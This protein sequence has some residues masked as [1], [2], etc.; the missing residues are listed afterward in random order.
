MLKLR[1]LPLLP[2][3]ILGAITFF[4]IIT[5]YSVCAGNFSP[6]CVKQLWRVLLGIIVLVVMANIKF[7]VWK[8]YAFSLYL[9]CLVAL[10]AVAVIGKISMGAQRWLRLGTLT[11]QPSEFMRI[12]L[13]MVLAKYFSTHTIDDNRRTE[14]LLIPTLLTIIPVGFVLLQP[15]LGT[16]MLLI[17]V[18]L[19]IL[20]ACGVQVWKF[21]MMFIGT[22]ICTPILWNCLYDYQKKRI[23]MFLNPEMDPCGSGYHII[24]SKIAL[25]SGGILGKGFLQGTQC[26]MN[27]LPE[28]HTD[29]IFASFAEEF[30]FIGCFLLCLLYTAI[31]AFNFNVALLS[32]TKFTQIMIFGLSAMMFFYIVINIAMVCGLLPVV[33]IPL[34]FFSYG[35]NALITLMACQG[36]IFSAH[37]EIQNPEK[38]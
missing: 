31:L 9:I 19:S 14:T 23:L 32:R 21:L 4:S 25:G 22:L 2:L 30:G 34:P 35:G 7:S 20:F 27:F 37:Y 28:K 16:A 10:I 38:R 17:L 8:K 12:V 6:W 1:P 29:F 24:Q 13:I 3:M 26:Q 36:L 33:G 11:L 5:L 18:F 15:D